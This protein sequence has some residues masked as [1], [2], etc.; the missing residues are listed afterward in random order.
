MGWVE[1]R[2]WIWS[3]IW[4]VLA[5][6]WVIPWMLDL[7]L[8]GLHIIQ[9]SK[10][11]KNSLD[12]YLYSSLPKRGIPYEVKDYLYYWFS[13][14]PYIISLLNVFMFYLKLEVAGL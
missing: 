12:F 6:P 13:N 7:F 3:K 10:E 4:D 8:G 1:K 5:P 11:R 9:D 14:A 2:D